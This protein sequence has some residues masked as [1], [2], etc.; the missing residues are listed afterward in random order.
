[1]SKP[2]LNRRR[3]APSV[4]ASV[5]RAIV[6]V[7]AGVAAATSPLRAQGAPPGD[8]L[9]LLAGTDTFAIERITRGATRLDS[10]LLVRVAGV[11][12]SLGVELAPSGGAT[13]FRMA[14]RH[15]TSD[16]ASPPMQ[17]AVVRFTRDSAIAELSSGSGVVTQRF[18]TSPD[19]VPFLNP[20]MALLELVIARARAVGGDSVEV[21][22]WNAQGGRTTPATV[23][24]VGADSVLVRLGAA[25]RLAID[26]DGRIAGGVIPAQSVRIVRVRRGAAASDAMS[27][28]RP[29]YTPPPG[30]PYTAEEVRIPTAA[31]HVLA[32]TLTI[33]AGA[34]TPLPAVITITGSGPQD[35]DES[36][37]LLKGYRPFRQVADTLGRHGIAVLRMD[38]RGWGASAGDH[39]AATSAD[40]AADVRAGLAYLRTR[41]EIDPARLA[42]VGHSEGGLIAPMVA[43]L[44]PA[45]RAI[46]L[47]AAPAQNGRTILQYQ[48]GNAIRANPTLTQVQRDSALRGVDRMIDSLGAAQPWMRFFVAHDP[49]AIV[50]RVQLPTLVLQGETDRQVTAEQAEALGAALRAGGNRR[51]EVRLFPRANHLFVEDADGAPSGYATLP[52]AAVRSD[53]LGALVGWLA[54]AL[55]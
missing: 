54:R 53:V 8:L 1:M 24:R 7:L 55:R 43:V 36:I 51:V 14:L 48:L 34:R 40:F 25:M 16:S 42:L 47:M 50:R 35:R 32:G 26:D 27:V 9:I 11:R 4:P 12:M 33:P 17:S 23:V 46:V 10:E 19:V 15:A 22:V 49:L 28:E 29:D 2:F 13:H 21:P 30:A 39:A 3:P 31:G 5:R 52:S 20:S 44:E 45:L 41:R 37:P 18:A 6:A 38:D